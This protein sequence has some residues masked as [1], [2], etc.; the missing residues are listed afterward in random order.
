M[1]LIGVLESFS[2]KFL[3]FSSKTRC[4]RSYCWLWRSGIALFMISKIYLTATFKRELPSPRPATGR[5]ITTCM[6]R[7]V[8]ANT[9]P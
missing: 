3:F 9:I 7:S 1:D 6:Q 5:G 4:K 2:F 8:T